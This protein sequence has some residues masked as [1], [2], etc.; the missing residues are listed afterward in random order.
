MS[1]KDQV[2][3]NLIALRE[4]RSMKPA[5]LAQKAGLHKSMVHYV[6]SGGER[7]NTTIEKIDQFAKGLDVPTWVL[8]LDESFVK[9]P[10]N[11]LEWYKLFCELDQDSRSRTIAFMREQLGCIGPQSG[12]N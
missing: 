4:M 1:I 6:E 8:F 10:N 3:N 2:I 7:S 5:Q 12:D 11:A 9:H